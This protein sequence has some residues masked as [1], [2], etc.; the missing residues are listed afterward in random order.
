M[1][2]RLA[3]NYLINSLLLPFDISRINSIGFIFNTYI[4]RAEGSGNKNQ[5][6]MKKVKTVDETI[7]YKSSTV[8]PATPYSVMLG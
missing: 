1:S 5:K 6:P 2:L 8:S 4:T 7:R 3:G